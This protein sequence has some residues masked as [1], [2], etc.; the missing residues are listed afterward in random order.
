MSDGAPSSPSP[1]TQAEELA[2][3]KGISLPADF[4][5]AAV[6]GGLRRSVLLNYIALQVR[7]LECQDVCETPRLVRRAQRV[8]RWYLHTACRALEQLP[9]WPLVATL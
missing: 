8:H 1:H 6:N 9:G 4:I 2:A 5:E 3:A 7:T